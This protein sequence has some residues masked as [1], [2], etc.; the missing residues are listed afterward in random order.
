VAIYF[1]SEKNG[2]EEE[3]P[4][5]E[6]G[7]AW[8]K[9]GLPVTP[10]TSFFELDP[11]T[12]CG[13]PNSKK[14]LNKQ[15]FSALDGVYQNR[16]QKAEVKQKISTGRAEAFNDMSSDFRGLGFLISDL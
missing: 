15:D 13:N 3:F 4:Q 5:T 12:I 11:N 16:S 2:I 6:L 14:F 9:I 7:G 10:S 1:Q 8:G